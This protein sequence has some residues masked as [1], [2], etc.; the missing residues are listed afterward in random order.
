MPVGAITG[1]ALRS[2][3]SPNT[4]SRHPGHFQPA[5]R[6][7]ALGSLHRPHPGTDG[8]TDSTLQGADGAD[9]SDFTANFTYTPLTT[10]AAL[11]QPS[12]QLPPSNPL[13]GSSHSTPQPVRSIP[14]PLITRTP[15]SVLHLDRPRWSH[16]RSHHQRHTHRR[17]NP[18]QS[19]PQHFGIQQPKPIHQLQRRNG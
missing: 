10:P 19:D 11:L 17:W 18:T 14:R 3:C 5:Q 4:R 7:T 2:S 6:T 16:C 15:V 8:N 12:L 1:V 9:V 13:L